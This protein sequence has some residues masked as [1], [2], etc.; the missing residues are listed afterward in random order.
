M[1]MTTGKITTDELLRKIRERE[2]EVL[3]ISR[4]FDE[5]NR[6]FAH[7][8]TLFKESKAY[9]DKILEEIGVQKKLN[10]ELSM[11]NNRI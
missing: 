6:Q 1:H 7:K 11:K 8:E 5:M 3:D 9:M 10:Q 4:E 2:Q